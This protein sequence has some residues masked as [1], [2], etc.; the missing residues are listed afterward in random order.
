MKKT[1][2]TIACALGLASPAMAQDE[3]QWLNVSDTLFVR[4]DSLLQ[5]MKSEAVVWI[6]IKIT[7][8]SGFETLKE[9]D[10]IMQRYTINC[11]NDT[12]KNTF[13]IFYDEKGNSQY[14]EKIHESE[15]YIVPNSNMS[16][17]KNLTCMTPVEY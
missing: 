5:G 13:M 10:Y 9:G 7:E 17:I 16:F 1:I 11:Y 8:N 12:A 2:L 6:R 4:Y 14:S 3:E 15:T